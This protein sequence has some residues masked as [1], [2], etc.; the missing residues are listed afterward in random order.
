LKLIIAVIQPAKLPAVK[1]ALTK[2]EVFR[3]TICDAHGYG[4]QLGHTE[5]YRGI[6]YKIDLLNKVELEILVNDDFVSRTIDAI[7]TAARTGAEGNIGDGKL[8]VLPAERVIRLSDLK[9]GKEA[10]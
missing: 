7:V 3:M 9:S 8:F 1:E 10:V 4:R 6:P 2:M 5:M